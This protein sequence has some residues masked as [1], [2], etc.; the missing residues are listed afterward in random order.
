MA[1]YSLVGIVVHY[2]PI[3]SGHYTCFT[4]RGDDVIN[5]FLNLSKYLLSG[6]IVMM[7][8]WVKLMKTKFSQRRL[9]F[10]FMKRNP[11]L[12][13]LNCK[14]PK[15][16]RKKNSKKMKI[17]FRDLH[18]NQTIYSWWIYKRQILKSFFEF[19]FV[20]NTI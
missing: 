6:F 11:L 10:S 9:M 7:I 15:I 17:L 13:L 14:S 1:N 3:D 8:I 5:F 2:G 18:H 20:K 16:L 12:E 19:L 4:K